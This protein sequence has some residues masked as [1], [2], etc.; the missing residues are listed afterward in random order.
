MIPGLTAGSVAALIAVL[1]SLPLRSPSDTLLNSASVALASLLAGV[2]AGVIWWVL[3][4]SRSRGVYFLVIWTVLF[5]PPAAALVLYGRTQLDHFT[6]F[7]IPLALIVYGVTGILTVAIARYFPRLRWWKAG[8][9]VAI[10][11]LI[12]FGLVNQTDQE[13]GR[14]ELPPPGSWAVP[15]EKGGVGQSSL[16]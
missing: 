6:A 10:A 5:V 9:A 1:V 3:R 15:E 11:L 8:I 16:I 14:L 4:D 12:G 13:S 7:A 2:L